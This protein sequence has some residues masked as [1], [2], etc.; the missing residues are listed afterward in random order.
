[1]STSLQQLSAYYS[2][3]RTRLSA[4]HGLHIKRLVALLKELQTY[5]TRWQTDARAQKSASAEVMKV[6][7]LLGRLN[8]NVEGINLLEISDYLK[9]SKIARKING[10]AEKV[11]AKARM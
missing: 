3:F 5:C 10:Y 2:R 4:T 1:L 11:A 7:E 6:G 8:K 9:K